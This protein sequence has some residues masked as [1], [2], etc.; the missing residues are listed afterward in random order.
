MSKLEFLILSI[1]LSNAA[2]SKFSGMTVNDILA[3][4]DL[5]YHFT[6]IH[7]HLKAF[8]KHG[9]VSVGAKDGKALTFYITSTGIQ[10][11]KEEKE[12]EK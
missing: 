9:I 8:C 4:E 10:K 6:T 1:L 11:L 7:N 3:A 2:V 12:D 5:S